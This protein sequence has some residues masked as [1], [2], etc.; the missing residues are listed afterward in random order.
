M[1]TE[2]SAHRIVGQRLRPRYNNSWG[3]RV[4]IVAPSRHIPLP[5]FKFYRLLPGPFKF[6]RQQALLFYYECYV[7]KI[8]ATPTPTIRL[9]PYK[10]CLG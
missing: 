7:Y 9:I 2:V 10:I 4:D 3:S 6:Y 1:N 5:P 8:F